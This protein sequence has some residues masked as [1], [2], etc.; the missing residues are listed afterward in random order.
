MSPEPTLDEIEARFVALLDGRL[1]R[2]AADEWA[3]QQM[4]LTEDDTDELAAWALDLLAGID[5]RHGP[6]APYLHDDEQVSG[7]L[8]EFRARRATS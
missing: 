5:L 3:V 6:G 2:E 8:D 4:H 7:W 1:T